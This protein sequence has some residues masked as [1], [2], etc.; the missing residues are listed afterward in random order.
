VNP[1]TSVDRYPG[2]PLVPALMVVEMQNRFDIVT[3]ASAVF[4]AGYAAVALR[5]VALYDLG[6]SRH[7]VRCGAV[8]VA[9]LMAAMVAID[10]LG[11]KPGTPD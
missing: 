1:F 3:I 2:Y 11:D 7:E 4:V 5:Y 10:F 9:V 8:I 6:L